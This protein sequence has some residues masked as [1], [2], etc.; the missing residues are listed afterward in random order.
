MT[1]EREHPEVFVRYFGGLGN[2]LF[3]YNFS[4]HLENKLGIPVKM[5]RSRTPIRSDRQFELDEFLEFRNEDTHF[6]PF[7]LPTRSGPLASFISN[8]LERIKFRNINYQNRPFSAPVLDIAKSR[9]PLAI[10][11]YYQTTW[12]VEDGIERFEADLVSFLEP[13]SS[14]IREK[15]DIPFDSTIVHV[16]IGDLL[17]HV[18]RKVGVLA[19][20]FYSSVF[21]KLDV[22]PSSAIIVT[23]D[24]RG[25]QS[26]AKE[27]GA[28]RVISPKE[29]NPWQSLAIFSTSRKLVC[30]NS[31]LSW[32]GGFLSQRQG[33]IVAMP[34]QWFKAE[35]LGP[36]A[37]LH[38]KDAL[39]VES[40]FQ[41]QTGL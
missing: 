8:R 16:R 3:Q 28:R 5:L 37:G 19:P 24:L 2:Q 11:G 9:R 30:S 21:E 10:A 14:G 29:A 1:R 33:S 27:V 23:D 22:E 39:L 12:L 15:L 34:E 41:N 31:T 32:W 18:N 4:K 26:L 36:G 20:G 6:P 35:E 25:A 13:I 17:H 7:Y 40:K 38:I